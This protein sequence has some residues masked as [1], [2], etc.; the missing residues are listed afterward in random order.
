[1]HRQW[2]ML[3]RSDGAAG[4]TLLEV[5]VATALLATIFAG[6][7]QLTA[8]ASRANELA[9]VTTMTTVLAAGKMEAL[10]GLEWTAL[11]TSPSGTLADDVSGYCEFFDALGRP[12]VGGPPAPPGTRFVRRWSIA[13]L[14]ARPADL[15][16]IEVMAAP[17]PEAAVREGTGPTAG[18]ARLLSIRGRR[19]P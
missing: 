16:R 18:E 12:F 10:Q 13:P 11:S 9:R 3:T 8:T 5:L 2:L 1:M 14:A 7:A 17:W 4:F 6:V 15:L 19:T